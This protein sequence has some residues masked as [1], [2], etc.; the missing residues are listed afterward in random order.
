MGWWLHHNTIN[1]EPDLETMDKQ[2]KGHLF[3]CFP[4]YII[5]WQRSL[6]LGIW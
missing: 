3:S 5:Y 2:E 1:E 6:E 4:E